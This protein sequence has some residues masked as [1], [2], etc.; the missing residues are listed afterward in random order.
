MIRIKTAI[1]MLVIA[2]AAFLG[3]GGR[4]FYLQ[5]FCR[6][7]YQKSSE[8]SQHSNFIEQ[9]RRG[10]I[11][12]CRGRTL[13]ASVPLET[14]FAEPRAISDLK[15]VA[16]ELS[17]ILDISASEITEKVL[18]GRNPG[19]AP[20]AREITLTDE[21]RKAIRKIRGI[22]VETK[23]KRS[24]PLGRTA[25]HVVGFVG[26]DGKALAGIELK[27]NKL[28]S[29]KTGKSTFFS[30]VARRPIG[31]EENKSFAADG[32]DIV[33]TIDAVIQEFTRSALS[34]QIT[35]YNAES[36]FAVVMNPCTGAV[37]SMVSLPDFDPETLADADAN[38]MG[39]HLIS[40]P[41]E[42][43]SIFKPIVAAWAV[44]SG[45]FKQNDVV[46]CENGRYAGKGFGRI[47]E[48]RDGF[49]H[50]SIGDILAFSSNIGMTKIGQKMG[51]K[52][53]YEGIKF[54]G[55][56]VKT[57]IDL[58]GEEPG[59]IWPLKRWDG[60][61]VAR[62]PYG[63]E[64]LVTGMQIAKAYCVLAN[65]GK[66]IKP[67]L[68]KAVIDTSSSQT[69]IISPKPLGGCVI[70]S[71]TSR[72]L[73]RQALSNAVKKGTGKRAALKKYQVWGKTGTA[74]IAKSTGKGY[75][76][77]NYVAS[78]AG[79]VPAKDPAIVVLV[80]I[81]KPNRKLGLGYTGGSVAAPVVNEILDKSLGYLQSGN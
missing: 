65:D 38:S 12:D 11:L 33:L 35:R 1:V 54:F 2:A 56:G 9:T 59:I 81:R 32:S 68:A 60:Y 13:A 45:V 42:P 14:I 76:E 61:S 23:W 7:F 67:Y 40:D 8:K 80:S 66:I 63:H 10:A 79:G 21:Q 69:K 57:G 71:E 73:V 55:F 29:G 17:E 58:P 49:G 20:V 19:Y 25:A 3:I 26:T 41:F 22:G 30:D 47:G 28:L 51:A 36:G 48:Y 77:S 37:L 64:V 15:A 74:N 16:N 6:E 52:K 39:N 70:N 46:F 50:L 18:A 53:I 62:I 75:D 27:Y 78:F 43:G 44:D 34:K 5:Y 72:W 4:C 31:L 24:Y